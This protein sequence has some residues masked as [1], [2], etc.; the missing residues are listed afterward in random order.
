MG[1]S[2]SKEEIVDEQKDAGSAQEEKVEIKAGPNGLSHHL[3]CVLFIIIPSG[4]LFLAAKTGDLDG[5]RTA[6]A[7]KAEINSHDLGPLENDKIPDEIDQNGQLVKKKK[8][9]KEQAEEDKAK[10]AY[11]D[12]VATHDTALHYAVEGGHIEA[13]KLLF[14]LGADTE[15]KNLSV[16]LGLLGVR[17]THSL[18]Q[19]GFDPTS[20]CC[21]LWSRR[22]RS[23][24]ARL[25]CSNNFGE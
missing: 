5:I 6:I 23:P 11:R 19:F 7:D 25:G 10:L 2:G 22:M 18:V 24:S 12:F 4:R 3:L 15:S 1:Q 14:Q 13:A 20:S 16:F 9:K 17:C 8:S 21:K